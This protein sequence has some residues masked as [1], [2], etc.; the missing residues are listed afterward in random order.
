MTLRNDRNIHTTGNSCG[1]SLPF[2]ALKLPQYFHLLIKKQLGRYFEVCFPITRHRATKQMTGQVWGRQKRQL[3]TL[4]TFTT[5]VRLPKSVS[6]NSMVKQLADN[7]ISK[8]MK[9]K[10]KQVLEQQQRTEVFNIIKPNVWNN[11]DVLKV[12]LKQ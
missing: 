10:S 9:L 6:E 3:S 12:H 11:P 7:Q 5:S 4:I 2:V 1:D 8:T